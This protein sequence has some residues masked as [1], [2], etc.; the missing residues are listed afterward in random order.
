[1]TAFSFSA[2]RAA[3]W[4]VLP[5]A[6][7]LTCA[8]A[9]TSAAAQTPTLAD[10]IVTATRTPT[11]ADAL[12]ADVVVIDAEAIARAGARSLS[13]VLV[14]EAG[15]QMTANGGM[16]KQSGLFIRG[17]EARHV[18]LL[19]DG[20]RVGSSTSG[21]PS[22]DN[23]PLEAIE[24]IEVLKGPASA[25]YGSDAIGG[26][27]Q[28]FTKQGSKGF[29]PYASVS[30][31]SYQH[32]QLAAGVRGGSDEVTYALS[33]KR[34]RDG[35]FSAT[36]PKVAFGG[37]NADA[38]P[39]D[40]DSLN[41]SVRW[42]FAT[43][44]HMDA[45]VLYAE[46]R[47]AYDGGPTPFDVHADVQT[48][49]LSWGLSRDWGHG[50]TTRVKLSRSDD[51]STNFSSATSTSRF[52]TA[53]EQQSLLHQLPSP[54]GTVLLGLERLQESV[55]GTQAYLVNQRTTT[56]VFAGVQGQADAHRWQA[57]LRRD[58]NSQFGDAT[59]GLLSYGYQFT[60]QWR[61]FGAYGTSFKAPSFN[62][63]Y[64]NSPSFKGNPTTQPERGHNRELGVA[65][66][67]GAYEVKLTRFDNRV[68]GFITIDPVVA[69]VPKARMEGWNLAVE[70]EQGAWRWRT[71]LELLDARNVANGK[72]LPRRADAQLSAG[73][74]H[75]MGA[76]TW[77]L[78]WLAVGDRFDNATNTTRLPGFGTL[79]V[80]A[81]YALNKDWALQL[82]LNNLADKVYETAAG[83]NQ[84]GRSAYLTLN[85]APR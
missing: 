31:G 22:L 11:R 26:V 72:K 3:A 65:Y 27:V 20:V 52:D 19:V 35:G 48:R 69:N 45:S 73:L 21:Q 33:V 28:I 13:E 37:H 78:N 25:L 14:R 56:A 81:R 71:Q 67:K 16:G 32:S 9:C 63:L 62:T 70:G 46:G 61:A 15:L 47:N 58:H 1:M 23:L 43:G 8:L 53:Q 82:R 40:Q 42:A 6:C 18:L 36:N 68:R 74:D 17:T 60:P 34:L 24:R 75:R 12:T 59:T 54:I 79:D 39:Y 77:G 76:W 41:A 30:V 10:N 4:G 38:D 55:S 57:N 49:V 64:W 44:W 2:S 5:L 84:P 51:R 7:A 66:S 83:Y 50:H 29:S 85:W 80:H